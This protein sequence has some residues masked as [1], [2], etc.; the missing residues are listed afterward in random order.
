MKVEKTVSAKGTSTISSISS[1]ISSSTRINDD[2]SSKTSPIRVSTSAGTGIADSADGSLS[3]P[4]SAPSNTLKSPGGGAGKVAKDKFPPGRAGVS[5]PLRKS[6]SNMRAGSFWSVARFQRCV[7]DIC[8]SGY[9]RTIVWLLLHQKEIVRKLAAEVSVFSMYFFN[10]FIDFLVVASRSLHNLQVIEMMINTDRSVGGGGVDALSSDMWA[11]C[12]E[13]GLVPQL[14]YVRQGLVVHQ[15]NHTSTGTSAAKG[16]PMVFPEVGI[17]ALAERLLNRVVQEV[18]T[19]PV[20]LSRLSSA[21]LH[22]GNSKLRLNIL[23]G[24]FYLSGRSEEVGR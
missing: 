7:D 19:Q 2:K 12:V 1:S 6:H 17:R 15:N 22:S 4:D 14:E 21:I 20:I 18:Q 13:Q 11:C 5:L 24:F 3:M 9:L 10:C 16:A 23:S 8:K